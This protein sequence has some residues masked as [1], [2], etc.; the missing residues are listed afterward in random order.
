MPTHSP[1]TIVERSE[2][3]LVGQSIVA[4]LREVLDGGAAKCLKQAV[5]AR[6]S[7]VQS[8]LGQEV[9]LVEV[10]PAGDG[11]DYDT[12]FTTF[13]G[14][15]VA[16]LEEVP[17]GLTG[18]T[19]RAGEYAV[20]THR[21]REAELTDTYRAV[22]GHELLRLG[23]EYEFFHFERWDERYRPESPGCEIDIHFA[24]R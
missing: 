2:M 14:F 10:Y 23:R 6:E 1:L 11:F 3:H 9:Y 22:F 16:D 8:R 18:R 21:G 17:E 4:S 7:E 5:L 12:P 19:L 15:L 24:I 20:T 13:I